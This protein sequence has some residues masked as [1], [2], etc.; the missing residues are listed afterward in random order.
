MLTWE[1]VIK[2]V[3]AT[4]GGVD[5]DKAMAQD[6]KA[7]QEY[8]LEIQELRFEEAERMMF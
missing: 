3:C 7:E 5:V 8:N 2:F 6:I 4:L 1:K